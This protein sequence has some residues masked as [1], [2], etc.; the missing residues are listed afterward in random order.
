MKAV[1]INGS[2][3]KNWNTYKLLMSALKGAENAGA[4]TEFY[5]LYDLNFTG[6]RSCF[7]CKIKNAQTHGACAYPDD[8]KPVMD[9]VKEADI[10]ILGSPVYLGNI[11]AQLNLF[12]ERL[13][14]TNISYNSSDSGKR[15]ME[16]EKRC[17]MIM[18]MG[19][20]ENFMVHSGYK[21]NF[22]YMGQMLGHMMGGKP[23]E[24]LYCNDTYQFSDY[25]KYNISPDRADPMHKEKHRDKQFPVDLQHA[26]ELGRRICQ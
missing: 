11:S 5:N 15:V 2:P 7:A 3:R 24:M 25:S 10:L 17:A 16:K 18:T 19:A 26:Y 14:F 22:D 23:A 21:S 20:P 12:W 6:C 9:A 1:F 13:M 8:L 4:Q